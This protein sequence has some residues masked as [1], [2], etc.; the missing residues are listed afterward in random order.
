MRAQI[1]YR[2]DARGE[3]CVDLSREI[4]ELSRDA[5]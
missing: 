1:A 2:G 5:F 3:Q 4:L